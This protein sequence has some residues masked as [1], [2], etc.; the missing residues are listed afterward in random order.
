[1]PKLPPV[2]DA[3]DTAGIEKVLSGT[4]YSDA[5]TDLSNKGRIRPITPTMNKSLSVGAQ[6]FDQGLKSAQGQIENVTKQIE[7]NK[8][9]MVKQ[10]EKM[11]SFAN[12]PVDVANDFLDRLVSLKDP[13]DLKNIAAAANIPML[14]DFAEE[15]VNNVSELLEIPGL[16]KTGFLANGLAALEKPFA[17]TFSALEQTAPKL[18]TLAN[19]M[20]PDLLGM[21]TDLLGDLT[22]V[23][24]QNLGLAQQMVTQL[25]G[26]G[27]MAFDQ[28]QGLAGDMIPGMQQLADAL[29]S[30]DIAGIPSQLML[31]LESGIQIPTAILAKNPMAQGPSYIGKAMF[32]ELRS[33][34]DSVDMT[35]LFPKKLAAFP[36]EELGAGVAGFAFQ[37]FK[38]FEGTQNLEE[39]INMVNYGV[40][41]LTDAAP[42][43]KTQAEQLASDVANLMNVPLDI[44]IELNRPDNVIPFMTAVSSVNTNGAMIIPDKVFQNGIKQAAMVGNELQKVGSDFLRTVQSLA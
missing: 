39:M 20:A 32:G 26:F 30:A 44:G 38:S 11:A 6:Q 25:A 19:D 41:Q 33:T 40:K 35:K 17:A 28:L 31:E 7:Q 4:S 9:K 14:E 29:N 18:L 15:L 12:I 27:N 34:I 16:E 8:D 13:A 1:M 10:A 5:T 3:D 42:Q 37:N 23:V 36:S 24:D 43:I 22:G 21:G 2:F